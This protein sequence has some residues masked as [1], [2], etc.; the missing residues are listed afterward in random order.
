MNGLINLMML[1]VT[2]PQEA[3]AELLGL[4]LS[5]EVAWLLLGAATVLSVIATFVVSGGNA[6]QVVHGVP[7]FSP[8][9][10]ALFLGCSSVVMGY[11]IHFTGNAM[12][13]TGNLTNSI[14]VVAWLQVLQFAGLLI[15]GVALTISVSFSAMLGFVIGMALF[16][17]VFPSF[18]KVLHGFASMGRAALLMLFVIVGIGLGLTLILGFIGVGM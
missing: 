5:R 4:N 11:A 14:L 7:A 15:Q 10:L 1:S 3:A 6:A 17:W 2:R 13:G 16:F 8:L 9:M 18:L 12:D